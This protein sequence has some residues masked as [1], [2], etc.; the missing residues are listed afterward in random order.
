LNTYADEINVYIRDYANPSKNDPY[1]THTRQ[2]DWFSWHSWAAGLYEFGDNR[3]QE[4]TSEAVNAYYAISLLGKALN[5]KELDDFG[6]LM[7]T[8]EIVSTKA[9]WQMP[10][11]S[12]I[13]PEKFKKNLIVGVLWNTKV[14]YTTFFGGNTEY[15]HGIQFL[16]FTPITEEYLDKRFMAVNKPYL[17]YHFLF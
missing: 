14:D 9:Y 15:I 10:S 2:K 8:M 3:N 5:N 4:S 11:Y 12:N 17:N 16:P 1:F 7:T 13:Y 6:R